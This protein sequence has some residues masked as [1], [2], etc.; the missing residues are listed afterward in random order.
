[1]EVFYGGGVSMMEVF[2]GCVYAVV[3]FM[4]WLCCGHG[5]F[6]CGLE[7]ERGYGSIWMRMYNL[8]CIFLTFDFSTIQLFNLIVFVLYVL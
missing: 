4:R 8:S 1:M 3:V 7:R 2:Y 6:C 5:D